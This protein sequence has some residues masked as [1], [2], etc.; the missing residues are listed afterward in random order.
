MKKKKKMA[1]KFG[2][3]SRS[4]K[5]D[6]HFFRRFVSSSYFTD[7]IGSATDPNFNPFRQGY[8]YQFNFLANPNEFAVLFDFYKVTCIVHKFTLTID[9][10]AQSAVSADYPRMYYVRDYDDVNPPTNVDQIREFSRTTQ[11]F[12]KPGQSVAIKIKPATNTLMYGGALSGYSPQWAKWID[13]AKQDVSY[14]GL[15]VLI[16]GMNNP[17]YRI[18]Q[19]VIYYFQCK[20][21]R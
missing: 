1:R 9:P 20:D 18:K 3:L 6:V 7:I 21:T 5:R 16:E 19:D 4:I 13:M 12:L 11:T 10:G 17:N 14:F 15:K 8:A 2:P